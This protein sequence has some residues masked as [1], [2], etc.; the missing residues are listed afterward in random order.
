[1]WKELYICVF[2]LVWPV[3]RRGGFVAADN[4]TEPV[5]TRRL[6]TAY[7]RH[8]ASNPDVETILIPVG[9]GIELTKRR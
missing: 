8:I 7:R 6:T 2:D 3:V 1:L 5:A 4:M 9:N